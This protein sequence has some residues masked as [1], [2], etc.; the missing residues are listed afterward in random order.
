MKRMFSLDE[1]AA[2]VNGVM[3]NRRGY[4]GGPVFVTGISTDS[5]TIENGN[6]YIAL[7]GES[8]DGHDYAPSAIAKGACAV[9]VNGIDK[10]P[11][12]AIGIFVKDTLKALGDL[13]EHYRF[14]L[15]VKVIA[16]TGSVGK[17]TTREM[18]RAALEPSFNV[19]STKKNFNNEIGLP[20]TILS[21]PKDTGVLLLEMGMRGR[22]QIEYLTKI[23]HPDIAV[24]TNVGYSHIGILGSREEI[25]AAKEE[26]ID[27]LTDQGILIVNG[28]DDFLFDHVRNIVPLNNGLAAVSV[29][30]LQGQVTNCPVYVS[31]YNL[32]END[33]MDFDVSVTLGEKRFEIKDMHIALGGEHNVRNA[34]FAILC[35][36]I[37]RGDVNRARRALAEYT[38]LD[39]RGK[40]YHG[41]CYTIINDAY[42]ASPESMA[43]AFLNL[44]DTCPGS[45]K[46]AI[47]GGMLELGDESAGLH[48]KTGEVCGEYEFDKILVTGDDKESFVRGLKRVR[49]SASVILCDDTDDVRRKALDIVRDGDTILFKASHSFGF[50]K[51]AE[52]FIAND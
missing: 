17:T 25:R 3:V 6:L 36:V 11:E 21:A 22:G 18:I 40:T 30:R 49:P 14:K 12:N 19:W 9:V 1:V 47:L 20:G 46:I 44:K 28:D 34:C 27:G 10:V 4:T 7:K 2:S 52:E 8:F 16:V 24:I 26:I 51:L 37:L 32:R 42:N 39:G 33:G 15:G 13:A 38:P 43:A 48:E 45:R 5:R 31:A 35:T 50:E 41:R 29:S 23:A